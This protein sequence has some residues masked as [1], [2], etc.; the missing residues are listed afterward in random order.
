MI[1]ETQARPIRL[2]ATGTA[3][4]RDTR[5]AAFSIQPSGNDLTI[6]FLDGTGG[7]VLWSA[8]ADA[9]AGSHFETFDP[10]L[11]FRNGIYCRF[12]RAVANQAVCL[13]VVEP[14]PTP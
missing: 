7:Q 9:A 8:E 1:S 11:R 13:S 2:T 4:S 5:L 14:V 10:P 6:D 3:I 12:S